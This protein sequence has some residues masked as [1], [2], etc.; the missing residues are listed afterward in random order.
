MEGVRSQ[1]A[2]ARCPVCGKVY[3]ITDGQNRWAVEGLFLKHKDHCAVPEAGEFVRVVSTVAMVVAA[4]T[5]SEEWPV[6]EVLYPSGRRG[7]YRL[8]TIGRVRDQ[9]Q[10]AERYRARGGTAEG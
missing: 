9:G 3:N 7:A 5:E 6:V 10:A 2:E 1:L 4:D 8:A